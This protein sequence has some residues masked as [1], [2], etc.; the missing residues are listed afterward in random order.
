MSV[1]IPMEHDEHAAAQALLPWFARGQLDEADTA[2]V[3]RHLAHCAL[4]RD[5]LAAERPMQALLAG[6]GAAPAGGDV[7][8]GLARL[9]ARLQPPAPRRE[10]PRWMPWALG[11]QGAACVL[12]LTLWLQAPPQ[13]P[14]YEGLSAAGTAPVAADALVMFK[15]GTTEQ[16]LRELLQAQGAR[17]VAGPTETGA[18]LLH[19]DARGLAA[20]RAAPIV[21]LAEPLQPGPAR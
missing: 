16:A 10:A 13:A 19:V 3:Q 11:L 18:W 21:Q 5:E 7:E 4:C 2:K 6:A 9:H 1:V 8:A 14:A 12:L 20:L 17:V 15:P